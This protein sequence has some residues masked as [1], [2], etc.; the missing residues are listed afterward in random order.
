MILSTLFGAS[1]SDWL[2]FAAFLAGIILFIII[3]E[4]TRAALQWP[5]EVTRKIVH[6]LVGTLIFFTPYF[7][8]SNRPLIW[9]AVLF[10]VVDFIGIRC[11]KLK[12]MHGTSRTSYGTVF[13]PLSFLILVILCWPSQKSVLMLA[14]LIMAWPDALAAVTG[15][16]LKKAHEYKLGDDKKSIEGTFVMGFSTFLIVALILPVIAPLDGFSISP[17][18]AVWI[19][20]LTALMAAAL[21][22]ISSKGSDNMTVP[23]GTAFLIWFMLN[24]GHAMQIQMTIGM[25][26]AVLTA[27][28][29]IIVRFLNPAGSVS[30]FILATLIFGAGGWSWTL[31]ILTFFL[32]SSLLSKTGGRHKKRFEQVFE[33]SSRRDTGQVIANGGLPGILILA[34]TFFPHPVWYLTYLGALAAVNADTWATEI[35]ILSRKPPRLITTMKAVAHG[36]SGGITPAGLSGA[37]LGA[38]IIAAS[39]WFSGSG[40]RSLPAA[41]LIVLAGFL[42]ALVD[43]LLGATLQVQYSCSICHQQ[44]EKK[45]H[46]GRPAARISGIPWINNDRVNLICA[47]FGVFFVFFGCICGICQ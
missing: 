5:P 33:K 23:L 41:G 30:T 39:G 9:M 45:M 29:S 7:F 2:Q 19:G 21:E 16:N 44:T 31:P 18:H 25:G 26:L 47:F 8:D 22:A 3:A 32:L 38:A 14:M 27:V 17:M 20:L 12:G 1:Q 36:V 28:F 6:I 15:E 4:K 35:G 10:I 13:Y 40:I 46:C 42:S 37:L 43:S 34:N 11:G 24:H